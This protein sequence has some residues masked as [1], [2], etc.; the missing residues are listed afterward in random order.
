VGISTSGADCYSTAYYSLH[1]T[2]FDFRCVQA[3]IWDATNG[4]RSLKSVLASDW[5]L[6]LPDWQLVN[7]FDI[8]DDGRTILC[9]AINP[10]A[11]GNRS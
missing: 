3:F 7:A 6:S 1:D 10:S 2:R 9:D 5:G 4:I 11:R 8:S